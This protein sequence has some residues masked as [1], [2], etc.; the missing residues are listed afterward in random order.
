MTEPKLDNQN[1]EMLFSQIYHLLIPLA[2]TLFFLVQI[3]H[4]NLD[5]IFQKTLLMFSPL[6]IIY[7][8]FLDSYALILTDNQE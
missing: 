2:S 5:R 1:T 8:F 7:S 3:Y 4:I 6:Q